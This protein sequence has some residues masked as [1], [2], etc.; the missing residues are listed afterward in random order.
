MDTSWCFFTIHF[1]KPF[2]NPHGSE[3]F[4]GFQQPEFFIT[5][6]TDLVR[7]K[8]VTDSSGSNI[9]SLNQTLLSNIKIPL[10]PLSEQ[11]KI[12]SEIEKVEAQ[13]AL[14]ETQIAEIP[15]QKEAVLKKYL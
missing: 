9:K 7:N 2:T 14:L 10:P 11:Q 5:P 1:K 12:V 15:K 13:I 6:K 8:I 4:Q 3:V